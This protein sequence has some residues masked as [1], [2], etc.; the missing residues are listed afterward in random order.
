VIEILS[1][2]DFTGD[3]AEGST[4]IMTKPRTSTRHPRVFNVFMLNDDF[5]PMEFVVDVLKRYFSKDHAA[6]TEI[7]LNIHSKGR[8]LCGV[9]PKDI[10]ETKVKLVTDE[11]RQSGFPL[12]CIMEP[13]EGAK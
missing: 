13:S 12:K 11:S 8:G 9:Y 3:D 6:A 4:A 1:A 2:N 10:A 5:T 7:M